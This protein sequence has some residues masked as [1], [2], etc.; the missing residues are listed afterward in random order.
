[1]RSRRQLA[2]RSAGLWVAICRPRAR[3]GA[4]Q[5]RTVTGRVPDQVA[6]TA[7]VAAPVPPPRSTWVAGVQAGTAAANASSADRTASKVAGIRYAAY[8]ATSAPSRRIGESVGVAP[9]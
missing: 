8:A 7:Q 6:V 2:C 1:M 5:L 4:D 3:A 9:R